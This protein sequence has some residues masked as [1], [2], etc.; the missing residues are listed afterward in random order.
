MEF[1]KHFTKDSKFPRFDNIVENPVPFFIVL[2]V[3]FALIY[4]LIKVIKNQ[5]SGSVQRKIDT[6]M[7]VTGA[8]CIAISYVLSFIKLL[9]L[10]QGGSLTLASGLPIVLFAY[11]YGPRNGLIAA[12]AYSILQLTQGIY[13]VHIVQFL[14][15]YPIA[16]TAFGLAGFFRKNIIPGI[17]TGYMVRLVAHVISGVVFFSSYAN[18]FPPLPY[19]IGYNGAF[20]IPEMVLCIILVLVPQ[21]HRMIEDLKHKR[22]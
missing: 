12:F 7:L 10:P 16:F 20:L 14:L 21:A 3:T 1:I 9:D 17:V 22:I 11:I 13:A 4:L 2:V 15:D 6:R 8:L 19:S 5:K 18:G